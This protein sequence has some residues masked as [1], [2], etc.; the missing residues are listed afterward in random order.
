MA[1]DNLVVMH[2]LLTLS[3]THLLRFKPRH[4][5]WLRKENH[6]SKAIELLNKAVSE[7]Q[8]SNADVS[9][10]IV[11]C[12]VLQ[13]QLKQV[14]GDFTGEY[15]VHYEGARR[16]IKFRDEPIGRFASEFFDFAHMAISMTSIFRPHDP[17]PGTEDTSHPALR[18]AIPCVLNT[19]DGIMLKVLSGLFPYI[20]QITAI[21]DRIRKRR[22]YGVDPVTYQIID[23]CHRLDENLTKWESGQEEN[24]IDWLF[25]ELYKEAAMIY[26]HRTMRKS[27]PE[28]GLRSRVRRGIV[29][30]EHLS[31]TGS[32]TSCVVLLPT[33]ML[34]CAAFYVEE[35]EHIE[36]AF[37]KLAAKND[38]GNVDPSKKIVQR[39][40]EMMDNSDDQSWDWETIKEKMNY[41]FPIA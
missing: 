24:S 26:L 30:L 19:F 36:T 10:A 20:T 23:D 40:W 6:R 21:R 3:G 33:F 2:S 15:K 28:E 5:W 12:M 9:D 18:F 7:A 35:R 29:L 4:D 1:V 41:D 37:N 38:F 31:E 27:E 13:F 11:I 34:G 22:D 32:Y 16:Y 8:L 25:A 17:H 14:E 39:V